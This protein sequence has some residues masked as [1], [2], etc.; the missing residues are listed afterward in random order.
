MSA[1]RVSAADLERSLDLVRA[2]AAGAREGLFG[3]SSVTWRVDREAAIFFGAGRALLLQLAHPWVAAAIADQSRV[4]ADPLGRFHRTFRMMFTMVFGTRD[5]ALAA[6][7][8]LFQ[9]HEAVTGVLPIAAGPF[10]AGSAY[11]ANDAAALQWVHATLV[12]TAVLA[13]DLVL[14]PLAPEE[15]ERYWAEARLYAGLFGIPREA[16]SPDWAGFTGYCR[17]MVESDVLSVIPQARDIAR[18]IFSG[19]A[20]RIAPPRWYRALTAELLPA[21]L[22]PAFELPFADDEQASAARARRW[23]R[24]AYPLL[25]DLL[26]MVGPYQEAQARLRGIER[27]SLAIRSLNRFWIG[28][29]RLGVG[30]DTSGQGLAEHH[31]PF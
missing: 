25:P 15:R 26:R 7:R 19:A 23:L 4:F 1:V 28:Q 27:P 9:R 6:A 22:R 16:L 14:P 8:R 10:A 5:Q 17:G 11:Y 30:H 13:H 12:E 24:R 18:Q 20:T 3:P 29:P 2:N 31:R 21:R